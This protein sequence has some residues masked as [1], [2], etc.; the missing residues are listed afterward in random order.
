M[1]VLPQ[2]QIS[3]SNFAI[4]ISLQADSVNLWYLKLRL[5]G[6]TELILRTIIR[7]T[8]LGWK[9]IGIRKLEFV[10]KTRQFKIADFHNNI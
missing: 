8:T 2:T 3:N 6:L 9:D 5:F 4:P 1:W 10:A 7:F